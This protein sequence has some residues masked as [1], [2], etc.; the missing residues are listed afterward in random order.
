M[1]RHLAE[2]F[3]TE[4]DRVNC[5][6]YFKIGACRFG[7]RCSRLHN[8]PPISQ[9]LVLIHMYNNPSRPF[10]PQGVDDD[11]ALENEESQQHLDEFFEDIYYELRNYGK[12][13]ELNICDNTGPHLMGNVYVKYRHEEDAQKALA[14]LAGRF[15][16]GRPIICEFSPVTDFREACCRQFDFNECTRGGD[17]NFMHLK[18]PTPGLYKKLMG[19]YP[20]EHHSRG[21]GRRGEFDFGNDDREG[22]GDR[23]KSRSR[24]HSR[25]RDRG[26]DKDRSG[27]RDKH[28][29]RSRSRS[30]SGEKDKSRHHHRSSHR[31][32]RSS[33]SDKHRSHRSS[34]SDRKDDE[35]RSGHKRERSRDREDGGA[36]RPQEGEPQQP[37]VPDYEGERSPK[38]SRA[39]DVGANIA[40]EQAAFFSQPQEGGVQ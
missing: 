33:H 3:C 35:G 8:K 27:S 37:L 14:S 17:C 36:E 2:I 18:K 7:E 6:F 39:E 34:R 19:R 10:L 12:V 15:Y 16:A 24:S 32:H 30:R 5:P 29:S 23:E 26:R 40:G 13:E 21:R 22:S 31:E 1:A 11:Q 4:K 28:K 20:K 9:S 38:R 25:D